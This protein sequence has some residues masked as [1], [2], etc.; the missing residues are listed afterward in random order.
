MPPPESESLRRSEKAIVTPS[1]HKAR[2]SL[3]ESLRFREKVERKKCTEA[4]SELADVRARQYAAHL[5]IVC[6]RRCAQQEY[7]V[8]DVRQREDEAVLKIYLSIN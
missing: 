2:T 8:R 4:V 3:K 1:L 5:Q 7:R 6:E